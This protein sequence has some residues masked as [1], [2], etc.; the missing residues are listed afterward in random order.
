MDDKYHPCTEETGYELKPQNEKIKLALRYI[1]E[2]L[3]EK[4]SIE[5][6]LEVTGY[7]YHY[8]CHQFKIGTGFSVKNYLTVRKLHHATRLLLS[9][10]KHSDTAHICG[11]N[12]SAEF[13]RAFKNHFGISP[14]EYLKKHSP[15][16]KR[17]PIICHL[18]AKS[19]IGYRFEAPDDPNFKPIE[20]GAF[21]A[22]QSFDQSYSEVYNIFD[23]VRH[24]ECGL[25]VPEAYCGNTEPF[26]VYGTPVDYAN[27]VPDFFTEVRLKAGDY[28]LFKIDAAESFADLS[29]NVRETYSYAICRWLPSSG[30]YLDNSTPIVEYYHGDEA[31]VSVPLLAQEPAL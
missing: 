18:E 20:H 25:W 15:S 9:G 31:Y 13:S 22:F 16:E 8:F 7:A 28:A 23:P 29:R 21:W 12:N 14:R 11:Y 3:E 4:I 30:R 6:L 1:D 24:G 5:D 17:T 10:T 2:H 27:A 26:Y 19:V